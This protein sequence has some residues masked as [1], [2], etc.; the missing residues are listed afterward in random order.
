[1]CSVL[2]IRGVMEI[3]REKNSSAHATPLEIVD[4]NVAGDRVL[5]QTEN[6]RLVSAAEYHLECKCKASFAG[7]SMFFTLECED[8]LTHLKIHSIRLKHRIAMVQPE[9]DADFALCMIMFAV[10]CLPLGRATLLSLLEFLQHNIVVT[11]DLY[12]NIKD[13]CIKLLYSSLYLHFDVVPGDALKTV[14]KVFI[15]HRETRRSRA[16]VL[17]CAYFRVKKLGD[18][19]SVNLNF[20]SRKTKDGRPVMKVL[21]DVLGDSTV[22]LLPPIVSTHRNVN[23]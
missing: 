3:H 19:N 12:S 14:P 23:Y 20:V 22:S 15:L 5:F 17:S 4:V 18:L 7:F 11:R 1:M 6:G 21:N 10:E 2:L 13:S 8:V 16:S 9:R